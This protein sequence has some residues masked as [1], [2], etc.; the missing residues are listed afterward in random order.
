MLSYSSEMAKTLITVSIN[1][2]NT[3]EIEIKYEAFKSSHQ[4]KCTSYP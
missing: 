2:D 4:S 3:Q 1:F